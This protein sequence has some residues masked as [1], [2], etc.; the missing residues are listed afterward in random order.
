MNVYKVT[1]D[2]CC[3]DLLVV[4]SS[5]IKAIEII[6]DSFPDKQIMELTRLN[7]KLTPVLVEDDNESK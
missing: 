2:F 1:I 7:N 5:S 6:K 3:M 4:A